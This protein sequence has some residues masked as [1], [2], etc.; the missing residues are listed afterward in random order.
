MNNKDKTDNLI[1]FPKNE[2]RNKHTD[3]EKRNLK[4]DVF[5]SFDLIVMLHARF[6]DFLKEKTGN[7]V[8]LKFFGSC[9]LLL[10]TLLTFIKILFLIV[11]YIIKYIFVFLF[12]KLEIIKH[13][14]FFLQCIK[15][16]FDYFLISLKRM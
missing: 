12:Y 16:G 5:E 1:D 15:D 13:T 14:K 8:F 4:T 6:C 9:L 2:K 7:A 3:K 11:Y 10:L